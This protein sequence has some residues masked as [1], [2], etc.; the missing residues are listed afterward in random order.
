MA[1]QIVAMITALLLVGGASLWGL[2]GLHQD[3][4][5]ALAGYQSL[6][7]LYE[8][9]A[10]V[11]TARTLLSA[12]PPALG[13]ALNEVRIAETKYSLFSLPPVAAT[14]PRD[15]PGQQQLAAAIAASLKEAARQMRAAETGEAPLDQHAL[16]AAANRV[17][18]QVADLAAA[19]R[20]S[21]VRQQEAARH[22]KQTTLIALAVLAGSVTALAV[23]LGIRQYRLV[24]KPLR[25]LTEGVRKIAAGKFTQR[26]P[27]RGDAEF[28]ELANDFNQMA[29]ELDGLYRDLEQKVAI[30]SKELVRSERLAS[31]GFLAAGVA[32]EINNPLGIITGHAEISLR[33]LEKAKANPQLAEAARA[34]RIICEEAFRCKEIIR[35]LLSLAQPSEENRRRVSM[36]RLA[37]HVVGLLAG[38]HQY[39]DRHIAA[40][41]EPGDLDVL[42]N[43]GEMKQ[44]LLNLA[45]NALE[46]VQPHVGR[47]SIVVGRRNGSVQVSVEDNGRGM[48][49]QTLERAFEP[50]FT[51]RRGSRQGLGLGLSITHAIVESHGGQIAAHSDGPGRG[52]RFVI[53]LPAAAGGGT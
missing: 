44:V 41:V 29:E 47:V 6:R 26:L 43:E 22:R 13:P 34:M 49:P 36:G 1:H 27:A 12:E 15:Q 7:H 18:N 28:V 9:T 51:E 46:A 40:Q 39:Q 10:H 3:F 35:K 14:T 17:L 45:I 23:V 2:N 20:F 31:V 50:F 38:L 16:V 19:I 11:A 33:Q 21:I 5:S 42:A 53:R 8:V 32:H 48:S 30:K 52:S 37:D 25:Q 24:M 4:G